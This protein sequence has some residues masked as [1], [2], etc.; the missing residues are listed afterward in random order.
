MEDHGKALALATSGS[1]D[2]SAKGSV[3]TT[4]GCG[5]TRG[6]GSVLPP[7]RAAVDTQS[8]GSVLR[9]AVIVQALGLILRQRQR[10]HPPVTGAVAGV[11]VKHKET[12][13]SQLR[14]RWKH[15][16]KALS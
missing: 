5:D 4:P 14:K 12:A 15:S 11:P 7:L 8:N 6:N 13:V 9:V 10:P 16:G 3:L 2:T 1:G